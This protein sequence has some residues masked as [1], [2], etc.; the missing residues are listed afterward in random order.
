MLKK[1]DH[2]NIVRVV[3]SIHD[4]DHLFLVFEFVEGGS[5]LS[6]LKICNSFPEN[7]VSL[8]IE[9]LLKGLAYLHAQNIVHSDIKAA[10]VLINKD[11]LVKLADFGI[12]TIGNYS[13]R[14]MMAME[15]SMRSD[16]GSHNSEPLGSPYWI[17]PEV[18]TM[19]GRSLASDIWSLGC[20]T[21]ELLTGAPPYY[22]M[23]PMSA[24][25][26][27]VEEG[28]VNY[29]DSISAEATAFLDACLKR[30]PGRRLS[31]ADLL[32]MPWFQRASS[33]EKSRLQKSLSI[34]NFKSTVR[35]LRS[36]QRPG[37]P[38]AMLDDPP[39]ARTG[40]AS[41]TAAV[42]ASASSLVSSEP[43]TAA[44]EA[45]CRE[46]LDMLHS[47]RSAREKSI[48]RLQ[49][50]MKQDLRSQVT[51]IFVKSKA[52]KD[53]EDAH[54]SLARHEGA[55]AV[56]DRKLFV[57]KRGMLR[58]VIALGG[59]PPKCALAF[60][61]GDVLFVHPS[62]ASAP[63]VTFELLSAGVTGVLDAKL[64]KAVSDA[65][66]VSI[67]SAPTFPLSKLF[68][69]RRL[70]PGSPSADARAVLSASEGVMRKMRSDLGSGDSAGSPP[71]SSQLTKPPSAPASSAA[72]ASTMEG[73][74]ARVAELEQLASR[75]R[76]HI[77]KLEQDHEVLL[78]EI[79]RLT[80]L[81]R[82]AGV[83]LET[84]KSSRRS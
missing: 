59:S 47:R 32:R 58:A 1:L 56:L 7:L 24:M 77:A 78:N 57:L 11:G 53:K 10:N 15:A 17:A 8:Y 80:T 76:A 43:L 27:I 4:S 2:P 73:L 37:L 28:V 23:P 36:T 20:T 64:C 9:Q 71:S 21:I 42:V 63:I 19:E 72:S 55:L 40:A 14:E 45:A 34:Q 61:A 29:P 60:A 81:L 44:E 67:V 54:E 48:R 66:L 31:A 16:E 51:S 22:T 35:T 25:F 82:A 12:A 30:K 62:A 83:D 33:D 18:I 26:R 65:E 49:K 3:D 84:R 39:E 41:S 75:D 74:R 13:Q 52:S 5:L 79:D 70:T 38:E 50:S 6:I 69:P 68:A 46:L